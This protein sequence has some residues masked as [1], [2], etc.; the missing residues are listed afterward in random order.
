[1]KVL[2]TGGAG[3]IGSVTCIALEDV[4]HEVVVVD[5]LV[6]GNEHL[7]ADRAFYRGDIADRQLVRRVLREHD[8]IVATIH[9]AARVVVPESVA[10][11][12]LYYRENVCKSLA[13]FQALAEA[14][15]RNVVYSSSASVYAS[16]SRFEVREGDR[17][18]PSSPYARTKMVTEEILRDFCFTGQLRGLSL[19]CFNP[20][21][22]APSLR[23]GIQVREPSHVLGQLV[24]AA[25]GKIPA[26]RIAGTDLPTRDGTSIRDYIHVWDVARAHVRAVETLLTPAADTGEGALPINIGTGRGTTV[27]EL[28]SAFRNATG[29]EVPTLETDPRPGDVVGAFANVERARELLGWEPRFTLEDAIRSATAWDA[30]RPSTLGW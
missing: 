11:P 25:S 12:G 20:I 21:G 19:R 6:T 8:D 2:V 7:V 18:S 29:S 17:L 9:M 3:Y 10:N 23:A 14:G 4:G 27:R 13:L 15:R 28:L 22:A 1:M 5:S 24:L 26:F 16:S 30:L